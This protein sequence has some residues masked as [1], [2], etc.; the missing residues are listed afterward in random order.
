MLS[1]Y[2]ITSIN[3]NT[4]GKVTTQINRSNSNFV[5]PNM[6]FATNAPHFC[7]EYTGDYK[8]LS[9]FF[10]TNKLQIQFRKLSAEFFQLFLIGNSNGNGF[11]QY[12]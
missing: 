3:A 7:D 6:G 4:F 8:Y 12:V 10:K 2:F 9:S 11:V 5:Q 1:W